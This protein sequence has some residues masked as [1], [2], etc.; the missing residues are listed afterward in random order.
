[1]TKSCYL[2]YLLLFLWKPISTAQSYT[3]L[4]NTVILDAFKQTFL[5]QDHANVQTT[6]TTSIQWVLDIMHRQGVPTTAQ[7]LRELEDSKL[8]SIA[9]LSALAGISPWK[10][11]PGSDLVLLDEKDGVPVQET[12]VADVELPL[13]VSIIGV[14]FGTILLQHMRLTGVYHNDNEAAH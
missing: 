2:V 1:M 8:V 3:S 7:K 4:E 13:Y 6:N 12:T 11:D 5:Q 10:R 14:M 9:M